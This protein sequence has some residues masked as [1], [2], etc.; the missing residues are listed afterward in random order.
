MSRCSLSLCSILLL[1]A[2]APCYADD[3]LASA[4]QLLDQYR[5]GQALVPLQAAASAGNRQARLSL[6]LMLLHG[7]D[8]YGPEVPRDTAAAL[9]WL[10]LAADDGCDVSRHVLTKL[11]R[12]SLATTSR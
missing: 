9:R 11:E 6:G 3:S 5:Y 7:E 2:G 8:L 4:Q 1:L 12:R 10:R